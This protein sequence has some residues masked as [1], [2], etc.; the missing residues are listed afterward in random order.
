[1]LFIQVTES[2]PHATRD[3]ELKKRR[4]IQHCLCQHLFWTK[5]IVAK[6]TVLVSAE[7]SHNAIHLISIAEWS[8]L[9]NYCCRV[10]GT[11][12]VFFIK[13]SWRYSAAHS[14]RIPG[15]LHSPVEISISLPSRGPSRQELG[16]KNRRRRR[17]RKKEDANWLDPLR[18]NMPCQCDK[19]ANVSFSVQMNPL[20]GSFSLLQII[21]LDEAME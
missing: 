12:A 7:Q 19:G 16:K 1:M 18:N 15:S 13:P 8:R 2:N 21:M 5:M 20:K 11:Q 3:P 14:E 10:A 4:L 6:K 9:F 17:R